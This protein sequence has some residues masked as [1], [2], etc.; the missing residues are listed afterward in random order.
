M[1]G[2]AATLVAIVVTFSSL[3]TVPNIAPSGSH[4]SSAVHV[5]VLK[6]PES[7][8]PVHLGDFRPPA[9]AV[10][11]AA[12]PYLTEIYPNGTISNV[13]APITVSG[14]V[15]TLTANFVGDI[16]DDRN[17][18]VLN[19]NGFTLNS[20]VYAP[21]A[22]ESDLTSQVLVENFVINSPMEGVFFA[23]TSGARVDNVTVVALTY[24]VD[25]EWTFECTVTNSSL[26]GIVAVFAAHNQ[27]V[28]I[29]SNSVMLP[30]EAFYILFS[31]HV[32]ITEN[33][34]LAQQ[35]GS[36]GLVMTSAASVVIANDTWTNL[37][38][39][40]Q[41]DEVSDVALSGN[42]YPE[43]PNPVWFF[44]VTNVTDTRSSA[45]AGAYGILIENSAGVHLVSENLTGYSYS[46]I[47]SEYSSDL[48]VR[49]SNVTGAQQAGIDIENSSGVLL[50][51]DDASQFNLSGFRVA[52]STNVRLEGDVANAAA[53][54]STVLIRAG[55]FLWSDSNTTIQLSQARGNAL[56]LA[57]GRSQSLRIDA[58][59][60]NTS[61]SYAVWLDLDA[62]I[63]I[64]DNTIDGGPGYG[65][66]SQFASGLIIVGN[67]ID[68]RV[69]VYLN[70]GNDLTVQGN[71]FSGASG[72]AVEAQN[73]G[74]V[75]V[76]DN[77]D[78]AGTY[79]PGSEGFLFDQ[80]VRGLLFNNSAPNSAFPI[81]VDFSS[82]ILVSDNNA[83]N[84]LYGLY[85][86]EDTSC[87]FVG[88]EVRNVTYAF[89][90]SGGSW[91]VELYHNN[92]VG[93][94]GWDIDTGSNSWV[95]WSAG[96][97]MGGNYWSNHTAP[98]L[99]G[100]PRQVLSG[101]DG[102]V[103]T[104]FG[105]NLTMSDPYPL[106]APWVERSI[107]FAETGL[108]AGTSWAVTLNGST[109][110]SQGSQIGFLQL[111]GAFS[112]YDFSI[113]PVPGFVANLSQ[114]SGIQQ[115]SDVTVRLAFQPFTYRF[116]LSESG[117]PAGTNWSATV[118]PTTR[119]GTGSTLIF[120]LPNGTYQIQLSNVSGFLA[121]QFNGSLT[122]SA[123][124]ASRTVL[125]ISATTPT[126]PSS[127][128]EPGGWVWI[129]VI[130]VLLAV[131]AV[132]YV[133]WLRVRRQLPPSGGPDRPTCSSAGTACTRRRR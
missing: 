108:P 104:S 1:R 80:V 45:T 39:G 124:N 121:G 85:I 65:I 34:V 86:E 68:A 95:T 27:G 56:S 89:G 90:L 17:G 36:L 54:G 109:A 116:T 47:I 61:G 6:V 71:L 9:P 42:R 115:G 11:G 84:A 51:S 55:F 81:D 46:A 41:L 120:D 37:T 31:S 82:G 70:Y 106:A 88:N 30:A 12:A 76:E 72:G 105:I 96:Y 83:S 38:V 16:L 128:F 87:V 49:S 60:F 50:A 19:G 28:T 102:I 15:Y 119:S 10:I 133:M 5:P 75:S 103:D 59:A 24:S 110:S 66:W 2:S 78:P 92:F 7:L 73:S 112:P 4:P 98:D 22:I 20:T 64:E 44:Y 67:R 114:G 100:G 32:Q 123:S 130:L 14:N 29:Q 63:S 101:P 53:T 118:G 58:S 35:G 127:L 25:C 48:S 21:A 117:L 18:S 97:P 3:V 122:I 132:G 57:D 111:N 94:G 23:A 93:T 33:T 91:G 129:G 62:G 113:L 99:L 26:I 79:R 52:N 8:P 40:I 131:A 13:S 107:T 69:G 125:F 126:S 43:T 77:S 74:N